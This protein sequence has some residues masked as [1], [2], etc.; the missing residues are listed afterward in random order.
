MPGS[1]ARID[2]GALAHNVGLLAGF[3]GGAQVAAVVKADGYGHGAV[4]VARTAL[5]AGASWLAVARVEE[6]AVLRAAGIDAPTMVLSE[7]EVDGDATGAASTLDRAL[8]L[9]LDLVVYR[10]ELVDALAAR[11]DA[12]GVP[13]AAVHLKVDTGMRRV[14]CEPSDA[15]GVARRIVDHPRLHLAGTCTHLAVADDPGNPGTDV[16]LDRFDAVLAGLDAAGIDPGLRHAANSA[17]TLLHPRSRYDLVRPG[18]ACYGIPPAPVLASV[19]PLRPVLRWVSELRF[20]KPVARGEGVSYGHRHVFEEPTVVG[21][22]P[23]GYADGLARRLGLVGGVVLVGGVRCPIRGVVTM[24]QCV[25]DLGPA[26]AAGV[27]AAVGTEVV[28][29]GASSGPA[30]SDE[31]TATEVG[32]ALDTIGYEVTCAISTRVPRVHDRDGVS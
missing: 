13:R 1:V 18:I 4:E 12:L 7:P 31:V 9:G 23:V 14:G 21:T 10:A 15:V 20:V 32:L 30:G 11:A 28:L 2:H 22:V 25:V 26:V 24:D 17:G 5:D 19:A 6:A 27:D 16:Q 8:A 3:A 29:L